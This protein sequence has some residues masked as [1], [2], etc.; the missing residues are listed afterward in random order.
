[1]NSNRRHGKHEGLE[2][3]EQGSVTH[4]LKLPH[5]MEYR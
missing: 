4:S 3:R 2:V 1:M 5:R